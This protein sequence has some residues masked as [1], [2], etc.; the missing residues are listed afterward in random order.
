MGR[1]Y[2]RKFGLDFRAVRFPSIVG[3]GV[4]TPGIVQYNA[5]AIEEAFYG[6][7]FEIWVSP[8]DARPVMYYK[9]AAASLVQLC[10]APRENIKTMI[11]NLG[12]ELV[13]AGDL[14]KIIKKFIPDAKISF[15]EDPE[16]VKII[17]ESGKKQ[18]DDS[19][20]REEWGWRASYNLEEMVRDFIE[21]LRKNPELY[22]RK[23]EPR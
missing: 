14:V 11:Y 2:A 17:R 16:L 13:K 1:F 4:R 3:P 19:R 23:R 6:R 18:I 10:K 7:P 21:E 20:A 9:D 8:D 5:W 15:K 22:D 12:A